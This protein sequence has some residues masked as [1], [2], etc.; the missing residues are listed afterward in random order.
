MCT[1]AHGECDLSPDNG[2]KVGGD[3]WAGYW[4]PS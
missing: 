1:G 2:V 4:E 3:P